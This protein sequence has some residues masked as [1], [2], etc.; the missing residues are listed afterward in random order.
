[1]Y[2][3]AELRLLLLGALLLTAPRLVVAQFQVDD[4]HPRLGDVEASWIE[5]PTITGYEDESAVVLMDY[6]AVEFDIMGNLPRLRYTFHR[7][8]K[9]QDEE[10]AKA[11]RRIEIPYYTK[12]DR[13]TF[14]QAQGGTV[15]LNAKGES[16]LFKLDSRRISTPKM[17]GGG[18]KIVLEFPLV[19]VGSIIEYRYVLSSREYQS[20]KPW[21]FQKD[22]PT[23]MSSYHAYIPSAFEYLITA[24][25]DIRN[26][27]RRSTQYT[28]RSMYQPQGVRN[29]GNASANLG[30]RENYGYYFTGTHHSYTLMNVPALIQEEFSPET[31]DFIPSVFFQLQFNRFNNS[32]N[33]NLFSSWGELNRKMQR[34]LKV[35]R[36]PLD[37]KRS[38]A[39]VQDLLYEAESYPLAQAQGIYE[40]VRKEYTWNN[41]HSI[42]IGN[43]K[44][45]FD[46]KLGNSGEINVVLLHLLREAGFKA[47]PVLISTRA[48][49]KVS[50][51]IALSDQ[52]N[53]LIVMVEVDRE[54]YFLDALHDLEVFGVLPREDLNQMGFRMN[55]GE[56]SWVRLS[57]PE[58]TLARTTYT[59]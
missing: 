55:S 47:D 37:R 16:V 8:I 33:P 23:L 27:Q 59:R 53:H 49:G 39:L 14:L 58:N 42:N 4:I 18:R 45:T 21:Y 52:F 26:L 41:E 15:G 30:S 22:I 36:L 29:V 56:G 57:N 19:K 17:E 44:Q 40:Y 7:R 9:I 3:F 24:K 11:F 54:Q 48:N 31:N 32:T 43:L 35:R 20:L 6:G 51:R 1:M 12:T 2:L 25:G 13:E 5:S 28:P 46:R 10:A 38:R 50:S 34:R